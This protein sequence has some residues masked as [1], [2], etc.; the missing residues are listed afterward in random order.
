MW[1]KIFGS[2]ILIL[3]C[4]GTAFAESGSADALDIEQEAE[5]VMKYPCNNDVRFHE[6]DF[7]LGDWVVHLADGSLAGH[8]S[9]V[10]REENCL[11]E[12]TWQGAEGG[13]GTSIN[14]LD[15]A[16]GEW[17]Q[18]WN[19]ASGT[20]ISIRG[21]LTPQGMLLNGKIHY[22][23]NGTTAPFRGLWTKLEDGRVRQFFEQSND[24]GKT[25]VPWFE[26]FYTRKGLTQ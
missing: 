26:G 3:S 10:S 11:L 9:I 18:V 13:T 19:S 21:G 20:Q 14:F 25:W 6:F 22:V 12:E 23:A 5:S 17:V 4:L 1:S 24:G 16:S 8:N 7:W 2:V 15:K